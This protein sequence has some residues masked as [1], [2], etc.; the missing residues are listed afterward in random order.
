MSVDPCASR[1]NVPDPNVAT[2]LM[3]LSRAQWA[4]R[5][6]GKANLKRS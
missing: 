3:K 5:Q 2:A 4:V 1:L 6:F